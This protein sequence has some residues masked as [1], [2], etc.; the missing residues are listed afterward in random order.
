MHI[1]TIGADSGH[2]LRFTPRTAE[3]D[4]AAADDF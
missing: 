3:Q 1:S 2:S 4:E